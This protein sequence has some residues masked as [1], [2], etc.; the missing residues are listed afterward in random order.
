MQYVEP[1]YL[2]ILFIFNAYF[3]TF[4]VFYGG[5]TVLS[6]VFIDLKT[7]TCTFEMAV[8]ISVF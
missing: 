3:L 8:T 6:L 4:Y 2:L 1:T 7:E 5:E